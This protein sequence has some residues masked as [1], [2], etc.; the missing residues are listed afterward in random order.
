[1]ARGIR[2]CRTFLHTSGH[3]LNGFHGLA[4]L[5]P[6]IV[7]KTEKQGGNIKNSKTVKHRVF[8]SLV[9]HLRDSSPLY[10]YSTDHTPPEASLLWGNAAC[11]Q[12]RQHL[13]AVSP[14]NIIVWSRHW[15]S[16]GTTCCPPVQGGQLYQQSKILISNA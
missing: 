5:F 14:G 2:F 13:P 8:P 4:I 6:Q 10:C 1:M 15:P 3:C 9:P 11:C 7:E 16:Q 12:P